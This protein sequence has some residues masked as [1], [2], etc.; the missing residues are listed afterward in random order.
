[1]ST[2]S[3]KESASLEALSALVDGE[4]DAAAAA[5]ACAWWRSDQIARS[6]WHTYQLIGDVL[7]SEDLASYA[8]RDAAFLNRLRA[9]IVAEPIELEG[10]DDAQSPLYI[11]SNTWPGRMT[12]G[13]L[14]TARRAW[15]M[16][17]AA[18]AG[19]A[20]VVGG[21]VLMRTPPASLA[22]RDSTATP[23]ASTLAQAAPSTG[24]ADEV[25]ATRQ[26]AAPVPA[27]AQIPAVAAQAG[28]APTLVADGQL[29]RDAR[30]DR[31]LAAHQ[32]FAGSSALG[33]PSAFVRS[34]ASD[35]PG[36]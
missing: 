35:G 5:Q 19:F 12:P 20:I 26:V 17:A 21:V 36:R 27:Q 9:R 4:L 24:A 1:M 32:Q 31:Y 11:D 34:A 33:L 28:D 18:A 7:R 10:I 2:G 15:M 6:T 3:A 16:P 25:V 30:L 22:Q 14:P 29:I 13:P 8:A 23:S